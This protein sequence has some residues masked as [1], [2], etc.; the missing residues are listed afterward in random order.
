MTLGQE[1]RKLFNICY[2]PAIINGWSHPLQVND[3]ASTSIT[4][5]HNS[6]LSGAM[7]SYYAGTDSSNV[8]ELIGEDISLSLAFKKQAEKDL[9]DAFSGA[10]HEKYPN[11]TLACESQNNAHTCTGSLPAGPCGSQNQYGTGCTSWITCD[12]G[13][14]G[15][16]E[17]NYCNM[18]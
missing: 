9:V 1:A 14:E 6:V 4:C 3:S 15:S 8:G 17:F 13:A 12:D 7:N 2:L 16:F 11:G 5:N 18:N 10:W